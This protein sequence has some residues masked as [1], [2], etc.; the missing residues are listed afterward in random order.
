MTGFELYDL[1]RDPGETTDLT[2][3][4][5]DKLAELKRKL[6]AIHSS[7]QAD[8]PSWPPFDD[9]RLEQDRI[10]WP[11]YRAKPL[12]EFQSMLLF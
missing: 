6:M 11:E 2:E 8:A 4:Q 10:E 9:P 12:T 3:K 1:E 5:P 7:V